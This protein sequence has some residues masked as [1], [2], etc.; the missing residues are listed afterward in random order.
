MTYTG[1]AVRDKATLHGALDYLQYPD[2][3]AN[4]GFDGS[5]GALRSSLTHLDDFK[6][7]IYLPYLSRVLQLAAFDNL[8][9]P[10]EKLDGLA[11]T[12]LGEPA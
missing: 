10:Q 7:G 11:L 8:V 12:F 2:Y 5:M 9:L 3:A 4:A 1:Q 6:R